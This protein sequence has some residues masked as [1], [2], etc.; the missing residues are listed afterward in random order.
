M[1]NITKLKAPELVK[2]LKNDK[3][4]TKGQIELL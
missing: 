1:I 4:L 3:T 2:M